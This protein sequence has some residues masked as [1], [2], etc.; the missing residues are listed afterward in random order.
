MGYSTLL[1]SRVLQ[2]PPGHPHERRRQQ[3]KQ[4]EAGRLPG[5]T[6]QW[7][8]LL[9]TQPPATPKK[10]EE[11]DAKAPTTGACVECVV[12][13]GEIYLCTYHLMP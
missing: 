13:G 2:L 1:L 11:E 9:S 4:Q 8:A 5:P 7:R 6:A 10:E 12:C 3:Q